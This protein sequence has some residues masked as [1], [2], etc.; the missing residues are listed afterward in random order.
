MTTLLP[1][2]FVRSA[3]L[4]V[5]LRLVSSAASRLAVFEVV[6][7]KFDGVPR[8]LQLSLSL[9]PSVI[10]PSPPGFFPPVWLSPP[11]SCSSWS[12]QSRWPP[13]CCR[14]TRRFSP[15]HTA[16]YKNCK[17]SHNNLHNHEKCEREHCLLD[18]K[19]SFYFNTGV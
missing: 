16:R 1:A 9:R 18:V 12:D 3:G 2:C 4:G 11:A 6:G 14:E 7:E 8:V 13:R 5:G 17:Y 10:P 15:S 19:Q